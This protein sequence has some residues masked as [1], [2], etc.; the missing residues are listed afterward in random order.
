MRCGARSSA[1]LW[2]RSANGGWYLSGRRATDID[3]FVAQCESRI[4]ALSSAH[5][6][7][8]RSDWAGAD[9]CSLTDSALSVFDIHDRVDVDCIGLGLPPME[10]Q[11]YSLVLH[12][13]ATNALK[14]GSLSV[15][16]GRVALTVETIETGADENARFRLRW[17]ERGGP[18]V[19][20]PASRGFGTILLRDMIRHQHRGETIFDWDPAGLRYAVEMDV[21][22]ADRR[23][24]KVGMRGQ[25]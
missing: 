7:L 16:D 11:A 10:A 12:E 5:T 25:A 4:A 21:T 1:R 3:A 8:V 18:R 14:H 24:Q 15:P 23:A 22:R 17:E 6:L 9:A 13:L 20:E 19:T 2:R